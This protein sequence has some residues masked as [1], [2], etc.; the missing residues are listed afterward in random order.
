MAAKKVKLC[1]KCRKNPATGPDREKDLEWKLSICD[2]CRRGYM[3]DDVAN[4]INHF[5]RKENQ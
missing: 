3:R 1:K 5:K 2:E 4:L